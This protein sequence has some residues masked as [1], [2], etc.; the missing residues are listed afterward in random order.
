MAFIDGENLTVRFEA[1]VKEG[2]KPHTQGSRHVTWPI[3][4][5]PGL[6]VWHP[7]T[8]FGLQGGDLVRV[9]YYST[10]SGGADQLESFRQQV[11]S[12]TAYEFVDS[13]DSIVKRA[14]PLIPR[15][16]HKT[17]RNTRTKSVDINL[18]VDVLEYVRQD[19]L[20]AI[21]LV[22]GDVDYLPLVEAVMR[23]GKR[24]F[25]AALSSGLSSQMSYGVDRFNSLNELYF[26]S[27]D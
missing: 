22:T 14:I 11:A 1:M 17:A 21:Y 2:R 19:A 9:H 27:G 20:D 5:E 7:K 3:Q 8:I 18:C 25:I 24:V 13:G 16:F 15:I 10:F 12:R 6:F 23:A 4:Y 26:T